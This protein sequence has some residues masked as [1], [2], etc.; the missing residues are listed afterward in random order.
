MSIMKFKKFWYTLILFHQAHWWRKLSKKSWR[1]KSLSTKLSS[2]VGVSFT[3]NEWHEIGEGKSE[4]AYVNEEMEV[5]SQADVVEQL[6]FE[7]AGATMPPP[8]VMISLC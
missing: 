2:P 6:N 5:E 3:S 1:K 8:R 4:E 7:E